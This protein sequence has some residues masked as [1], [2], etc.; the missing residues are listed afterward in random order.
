MIHMKVRLFYNRI[1]Y[2]KKS[3]LEKDKVYY[4]EL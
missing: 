4:Y 3:F 2:I 1:I